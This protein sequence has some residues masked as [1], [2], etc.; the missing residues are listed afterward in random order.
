MTTLAIDLGRVT[1]AP[2]TV[3]FREDEAAS[4]LLRRLAVRRGVGSVQDFLK[5]IPHCPAALARTVPTGQ[6]LDVVARLSGFSPD[7]IAAST[8]ARTTR[9]Y[10]LGKVLLERGGKLAVGPGSTGKVCPACLLEDRDSSDG[11]TDCRTYRRFW[12]DLDGIDGC[13]THNIPLLRQC[14]ECGVSSHVVNIRP[15]RCRCGLD[16]AGPA[17]GATTGYDADVLR[18]IRGGSRPWW[19]QGLSIRSVT[20][21][22]LRVGLLEAK[23]SRVAEVRRLETR[24]R[25]EL[26]ALGAAL[27]DSGWNEIDA[28][29]DRRAAAGRRRNAGEIYGDLLKWL[30]RADEEGLTPFKGRMADHAAGV[31]REV[32][33]R[34]MFGLELDR[35]GHSRHSPG[36]RKPG[37]SVFRDALDWARPRVEHGRS[38]D[39]AVV[40]G[41]TRG[42]VDNMMFK[43]PVDRLEG[44]VR[45]R[46]NTYRYD[47]VGV[48][49]F[50]EAAATAPVFKDV[51]LTLVPLLEVRRLRRSWV[52]VYRALREG[53]L[54]VAGLREGQSGLAAILVRRSD[55]RA[56]CPVER[57]GWEESSIPNPEARRRL[58][59]TSGTLKELRRRGIVRFVRRRSADDKSSNAPSLESVEAF[60]RE[61]VT[62]VGL[63]REFGVPS[64]GLVK[65]LEGAGIRTILENGHQDL[66]FLRG[67]A[68]AVLTSRKIASV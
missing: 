47:I 55:A 25:M 67:E 22:A 53:R 6:H 30:E 62:S 54:S 7:A 14:P 59:L 42:Q 52:A 3:R 27:L 28:L 50:L 4:S 35:L 5:T 43:D 46:H 58:G 38:E 41:I 44:A 8:P 34:S 23:G 9:G 64:S 29:F 16:L 13:P 33:G 26:T 48:L 57:P 36:S 10:M 40:L 65:A 68:I 20:N 2:L 37:S 61:Y 17:E 51:P 45:N 32:H 21:L 24:Q 66:V 31:L 39:L 18:M 56:A 49:K 15:D 1:L 12:W 19:A 11:P 63:G 60:E